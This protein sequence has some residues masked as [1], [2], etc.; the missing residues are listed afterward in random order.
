MRTSETMVRSG[1]LVPAERSRLQRGIRPV[2]ACGLQPHSWEAFAKEV[3]AALLRNCATRADS[4]IVAAI[5][6][7]PSNALLERRKAPHQRN[8]GKSPRCNGIRRGSQCNA[9]PAPPDAKQAAPPILT[10]FPMA[11]HAGPVLGVSCGSR[12]SASRGPRMAT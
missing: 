12:K 6:F 8:Y 11:C 9:A 2:F 10:S 5:I 7:W 1:G 4:C 3:L